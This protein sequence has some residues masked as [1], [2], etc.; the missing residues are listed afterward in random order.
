MS[1][2]IVFVMCTEAGQLEEEAILLVESIRKYG[3]DLKDTPIYSFQV[4]ENA[5]ISPQTF[6]TLE[7]FDVCHNRNILNTKYPNYPLANKP[8]TCAYAEQEIDAEIIVF[9]DSD[10]VFFSEPK[11][12]LLPPGYDV[13]LR[14]EHLKFIA[15]EG[16]SDPNDQYWHEIYAVAGLKDAPPFVTTTVDQKKVRAYWNSGLIAARRSAGIFTTWKNNFENLVSTKDVSTTNQDNFYLEQSIFAATICAMKANIWQFSVGYN[17]PI[18]FHNK[19]L[20]S[21]Q[22][23]NF[24]SIVCI[25]DHLFRE[26]EWFR[27]RIWVKTLKGLKNFDR[28]SP[29]YQ[30]LYAYLSKHTTQANIV[31]ETLENILFTPIVQKILPSKR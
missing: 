5:E 4:R 15:S 18:H 13:G 21:E 7:S 8:L 28:T 11:E 26:R 27:E 19:L 23:S 2:P 24:E 17:Y 30:W 25:H 29:Q 14:P 9:L 3:G 10:L 1:T 22:L 16:E 6:K 31:Q 20:K 12:F